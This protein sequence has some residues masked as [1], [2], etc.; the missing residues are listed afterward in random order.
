MEVGQL[1]RQVDQFLLERTAVT[2]P[3]LKVQ[4]FERAQEWIERLKAV[5]E[6]LRAKRDFLREVLKAMNVAWETAPPTGTARLNAL[7]MQHLEKVCREFSYLTRWGGQIQE[8]IVQLS[9]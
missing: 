2:S 6:T 1:C 3:L 4:M 8:R 9:I 7:P 5:Q